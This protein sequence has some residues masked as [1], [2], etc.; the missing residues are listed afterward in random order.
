M[1]FVPKRRL[2]RV[3]KLESFQHIKVTMNNVLIVI[4]FFNFNY[5]SSTISFIM[6]YTNT[7]YEYTDLNS[8]IISS[9]PPSTLPRCLLYCLQN[10]SCL[11]I[12]FQR[13]TGSCKLLSFNNAEQH[14]AGA[15]VL[16]PEEW[17]W[18]IIKIH[19]LFPVHILVTSNMFVP[20]LP[21][22]CVGLEERKE[23]NQDNIIITSNSNLM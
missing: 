23:K 8:S 11:G 14:T 20:V 9:T 3:L 6:G 17:I 18:V 10:D 4:L 5:G 12:M 2:S 7:K 13:S 21:A 19:A 1:Q 15:H 16:Q 22:Q